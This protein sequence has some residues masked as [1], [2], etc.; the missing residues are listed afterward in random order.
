MTSH[1]PMFAP[2]AQR[3]SLLSWILYRPA[4][5]PR[6]REGR[7]EN[8]SR[9]GV[10]FHGAE[11]VDVHVPVEIMM[12]LPAEVAGSAAGASVGRGRIVR[13]GTER[14]DARPTFAAAITGWETVR[15]DPKRS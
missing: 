8:V 15:M 3:V 12:T 2:R 4:G 11:T 10:L 9:S 5:D 7:T 6:W 14:S 13:H 1:G